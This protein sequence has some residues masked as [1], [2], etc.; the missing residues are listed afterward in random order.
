[1]IGKRWRGLGFAWAICWNC[2]GGP[3][4]AEVDFAAE[5]QPVLEAACVRCHREGKAE[6]GLRLDT[7][8][9]ALAGGDSGPALVP[10]DAAGSSLYASAALPADDP[11]AMP[12]DEPPLAPRQL[13][14]IKAWIEAGAPW[15]AEL[16]L[17]AQPRIDF[18]QHVRPILAQRC[19]SCHHAAN[20]EADFDLSTWETTSTSGTNAP[21]V[22]PFQPARSPL[23]ALAALPPDDE[24]LMPPVEAGGPLPREDLER[25]RQWIA[26]GAVWPVNVVVQPEERPRDP[27]A[28]PDNRQLLEEIHG[29]IAAAPRPA[30]A[31]EMADYEGVIPQ[32]GVKYPMAAVPGG[33]FLMGSPAEEPHRNADEGPQVRVAVSPFW[34]GRYEVT[35]DQYEPFMIN[36]TDRRKDGSLKRFDPAV[37]D[38]V[39][40]VSQPTA[41]YMEMSFGMGRTGYPAISMT[42]H[43]ASKFCQWLSAQTGHF[44]RL[45][46]EAECEYACRAGAETAYSFGDDPAELDKYAWYY[47]NSDE[48]YH[49]VGQKKP[50]SWGLYD[51]HGNVMEWTLDAYAVDYFAQIAANPRDPHRKPT[52]LYPQTVR[53]GGWDDDPDK[54]R[55]AARRG[56]E[57]AWKQQDPQLPKSVWYHT[58]A[59]W[60][61]FRIVRPLDV[62]SVDQ[63]DDAWNSVRD[64][65]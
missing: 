55:A 42:Q 12:P 18:E 3:T 41:P 6:G 5:V 30:S 16:R 35:W 54:L 57:A 36:Q 39:D 53:G 38:L 26:Q 2:A 65:R 47:D 61:G 27:L 51:M 9:A 24:A 46:T 10:G 59:R 34:I 8:E 43:A 21:A 23:F 44:Y 11:A 45:P 19:A 32:T 22:T 40:A 58:D 4:R 15:P 13:A 50:N 49:K 62:P 64:M 33:E 37:H 20:A 17:E 1:M 52:A 14:S 25:L 63:M 48:R 60:L 31:G 7:R 29:K 56:S 28:S